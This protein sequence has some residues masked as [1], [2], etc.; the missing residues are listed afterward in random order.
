MTK[1]E[2]GSLLRNY[3]ECCK[4]PLFP[5]RKLSQERLGQ[6]LGT[7]LGNDGYSGAAVSDWERGKS[8]IHADNRL[9][10]IA[11]I[12]VLYENGGLKTTEQ[13][14]QLLEARNYRPLNVDEAGKIFTEILNT[15]NL[16]L[17]VDSNSSAGIL[18]ESFFA[19]IEKE[20]KALMVKAKQGGPDPWWPRALAA[21]MRKI[22]DRFSISLRMILWV[23]VWL[24]AWWLMGPSL[25]LSF[26][27]QNEMLFAMQKYAIGSLII[28][29]MIGLLINTKDSEYWRLQAG[30]DPFLLR[31]YTY[32]GS[33]IG[34]NLGY[35][36][37]FPL[38][39]FGHYLQLESSVWIELLAA[40]MGLI[41]GNMGARVVPHNLWRAF[42]RLT[43]ADGAI[44]FVV[45]LMGPLWAFFFLE[46]YPILLN[47]VTGVLV[48]LLAITSM[49][50]I[51]TRKSKNH[52]K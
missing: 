44:F 25:R 52:D 10:L 26:T 16:Q 40:T 39:L 9:V 5:S 19:G 31:L 4:D 6:L 28:P 11:L 34:F 43:W 45:A 42:G 1:D 51:A 17:E 30:A 48:I 24:M 20:F 12:K 18:K 22:T 29:L 37:V 8:K 32:Q 13:A 41:L 47:P 35:F 36:F 49:V 38:S 33:G 3:R 7:E 27:D 21:L 46:Y 50:F 14:N 2:F 15:P 23:W